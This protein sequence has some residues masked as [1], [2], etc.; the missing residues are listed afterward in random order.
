MANAL[1]LGGGGFIGSHLVDALVAEGHRVTVFDRFR[2]GIPAV[3]R[4]GV[5]YC[6]GD[7]LDR[8][9]LDEAVVGHDWVFHLLS[10]TS[11]ATAQADPTVDLQTNVL[12]SVELFSACVRADVKHVY[13]ASTGGAIYGPQNQS[14]FSE[15]DQ[16]LPVSPYGIG[17]LAIEN[18][19]RYFS[20]VHGLRSTSL[21]ISN[22][23]GTRQQPHRKQGF[24]PIALRSIIEGGDVVQVGDGSMVRDYIL[25]DD[26][27]AMIVRLTRTIPKH[28]VYNLGSGHGA[29]VSDVI[30]AM[31]RV[32]RVDF[33]IELR[34]KLSTFVD[35]SVLNVDRFVGEFGAVDLTPLD[36][37]IRQTYTEML[38][39]HRG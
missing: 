22:P 12:Q 6:A 32:T 38:E 11:P 31:R 21:R 5:V 13:F 35:R 24:I 4:P 10:T 29:S 33:G 28:D 14:E 27:V 2:D 34:E 25:V 17:K 15:L 20:A 3:A 19:L 1:V 16:T 30:E 9:S 8:A 37:G 18:Y 23:Y 36:E 26:L 39:H 7:F